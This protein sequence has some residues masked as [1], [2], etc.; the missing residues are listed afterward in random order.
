[1]SGFIL[2]ELL[3]KLPKRN[4]SDSSRFGSSLALRVATADAKHRTVVYEYEV[5]EDEI[6]H[7]YLAS[8]WLSTIVDHATEPLVCL[9]ANPPSSYAT[10]LNV[11]TLEPVLP[12]T[13]IEIA[14]KL[15]QAEGRLLQTTV[16][17]RDARRRS[18]VYATGV[19]SLICKDP[20]GAKL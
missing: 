8:G 6:F 9:T 13:R 4:D 17:F 2:D 18:V 7:G 3:D 14:C 20:V 11:H 5:T 15:V 16:S 10:S 19:Q 12:G 1:M